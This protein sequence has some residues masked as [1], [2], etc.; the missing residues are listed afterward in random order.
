MDTVRSINLFTDSKSVIERVLDMINWPYYYSSATTGADWDV[1]QAIVRVMK[2]FS[3]RPILTHVLGHQDRTK[4][5]EE[6]PLEAQLNVD[7]DGLAGSYCYASDESATIVPLIEGTFVLVHST[8]GTFTS[9][10]KQNIRKIPM[11]ATIRKYISHKYN[12][13]GQFD[14]VDWQQHGVA[15]RHNY[16]I[17]HFLSKYVH[18]WLPVGALVSRYSVKYPPQCPSCSCALETQDHMLRCPKQNAQRG[19]LF[20]N[21]KRF[22]DNYPT[23]PFLRIL[24]LRKLKISLGDTSV[25]PINDSETRFNLL[26]QHQEDIGW[27]QL[28]SGRFAHEW[29]DVAHDYIS[30]I[31]KSQKRKNLSGASWVNSVI[32]IIF[33]FALDVWKERNIDRHGRDVTKSEIL[34]IE[35]ALLQTNELYRQRAQVLPRHK[36]LFYDTFEQHKEIEKT[37]R[38]LNQW[39]TTW[40]PLLKHS[41]LKAKQFGITGMDTLHSFFTRQTNDST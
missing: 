16:D 21:L 19:K 39:I 33:N 13:Q 1:L 35:R 18:N 34:L 7:A 41:I 25:T 23:D 37:S 9:R 36:Y 4:K 30:N 38:S 5:Y 29:T 12:W 22:M 28:L 24:L 3:V 6:L 40:S 14:L 15:I 27:D 32:K 26:L 17:K 20:V 31:P 8:F 11:V 2:T 10:Y